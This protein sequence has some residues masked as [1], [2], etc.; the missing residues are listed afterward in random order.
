MTR[1]KEMRRRKGM[2]RVFVDEEGAEKEDK[3]G[4]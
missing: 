2:K 1:G 3:E 4:L